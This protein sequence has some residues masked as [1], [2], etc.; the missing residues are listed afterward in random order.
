[1]SEDTATTVSGP[2]QTRRKRLCDGMRIGVADQNGDDLERRRQ[3]RLEHYQ[4]HFERMLAHEDARVDDNTGRLRELS[5]SDGRD[6]SFAER[7]APLRRRMNRNARKRDAM[8]GANDDDAAWWFGAARPRA[9]RCRGDRT[10]V[11]EASVWCD[12]DLW[13]DAAIRPSA[14]AR[15]RNQGRSACLGP[16]GKT[17]PRLAG[18]GW[19]RQD[20]A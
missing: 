13:R 2:P 3:H 19:C 9:E 18:G 20:S 4:M 15:I 7:R 1:M 5:M 6:R 14:L 11:D 17:F 12:D 8:G 10:R 16:P